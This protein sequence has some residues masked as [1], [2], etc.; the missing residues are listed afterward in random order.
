MN[1]IRAS[2]SFD[3]RDPGRL[4]QAGAVAVTRGEGLRRRGG[5]APVTVHVPSCPSK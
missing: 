4:A 3:V 2:A 1:P 5:R